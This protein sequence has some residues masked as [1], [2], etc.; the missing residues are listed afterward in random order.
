MGLDTHTVDVL[1]RTVEGILDEA[2]QAYDAGDIDRGEALLD[3]A[4][5]LQSWN[6][7]SADGDL[8]E[9]E[10]EDDEE[11]LD[12]QHAHDCDC[13][14]CIEHTPT[15]DFLAKLEAR[16]IVPTEPTPAPTKTGPAPTVN[17]LPAQPF[18]TGAPCLCERAYHTGF[19]GI[20]RVDRRLALRY[21]VYG[22]DCLRRAYDHY[23]RGIA[24]TDTPRRPYCFVSKQ[25]RV[26]THAACE[27][28][29]YRPPTMVA[30]MRHYVENVVCQSHTHYPEMAENI[31]RT[32]D[33][34][35]EMDNELHLSLQWDEREYR[36]LKSISYREDAERE[37]RAK[38]RRTMNQEWIEAKATDLTGID[39][40]PVPE[41]VRMAEAGLIRHSGEAAESAEA[42]FLA[43]LDEV[44]SHITYSML[45]EVA[46]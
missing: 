35:P 13:W 25:Q 44:D 18:G 29:R 12:D 30:K 15:P 6:D 3:E 11:P 1:L 8:S 27:H 17:G 43:M 7:P 41:A 26:C 24:Y 38:S 45:D 46:A 2:Q 40:E 22:D 36:L 37:Q 32:G 33:T 14:F 4:C 21:E 10:W 20:P 39:P 42:A 23:N 9:A 28:A 5:R 31:D 34:R 19:T 16:L